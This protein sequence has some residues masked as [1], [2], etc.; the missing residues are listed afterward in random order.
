M[1]IYSLSC[2]AR[3]P[4]MTLYSNMG[5]E[6]KIA[7]P[8]DSPVSS[9]DSV[10]CSHILLLLFLFHLSTMYLLI[11][12]TPGVVSGYL[13]S[14]Q[15]YYAL[16]LCGTEQGSSL[17]CSVHQ[18]RSMVVWGSSLAWGEDTPIKNTEEGMFL[19]LLTLA[20]IHSFTSIRVYSRIL[21]YTEDPLKHPVS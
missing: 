21:V 16:P 2:R 14:S 13:G 15:E 19:P 8:H 11:L 10:H 3:N 7:V 6:L 1:V 20:R 17:A 12:V 4:D 9:S 18:G 5:Q